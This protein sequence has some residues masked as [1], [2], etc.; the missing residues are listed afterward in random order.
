MATRKMTFTLPEELA[1][2]FVR[3]VSARN[4]SRYLT[5]ALSQKLSERDRRLIR[6]AQA[7]NKNREVQAIEKEFDAL[8]ESSSGSWDAAP[9]RR[10]VGPPR[11]RP[12]RG[13]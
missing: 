12:R 5:E 3:R 7:A 1:A 10:V 9:R 2:Q 8:P 4:R 11:S 13:N 6:S